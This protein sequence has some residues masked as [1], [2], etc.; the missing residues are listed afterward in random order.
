MVSGMKLP[1]LR[2]Q[3]IGCMHGLM[4]IIKFVKQFG[5]STELMIL[6]VQ[7]FRNHECLHL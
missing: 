1:L 5:Y 6:V 4:L 7:L 2:T 3:S